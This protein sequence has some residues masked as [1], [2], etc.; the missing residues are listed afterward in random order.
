[1][2]NKFRFGVQTS[3]DGASADE[4]RAILQGMHA[5]VWADAA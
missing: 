5:E 2:S 1:M 4:A 3:G